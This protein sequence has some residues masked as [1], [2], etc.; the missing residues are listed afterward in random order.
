MKKTHPVDGSFY[1]D[2]HLTNENLGEELYFNTYKNFSNFIK[3]LGLPVSKV[4]DT[5][6]TSGPS[7][8][9][10]WKIS[11]TYGKNFK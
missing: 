10:G 7:D 11:K 3:S 6:R 1:R 4:Y 8:V 5:C 9:D 2:I